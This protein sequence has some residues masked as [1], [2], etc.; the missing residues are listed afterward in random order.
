MF[1]ELLGGG[2]Q[3]AGRRVVRC[4]EVEARVF[5]HPAR[6]SSVH[7]SKGSRDSGG[8]GESDTAFS[9]QTSDDD[10]EDGGVSL[11]EYMAPTAPSKTQL[12]VPEN[13]TPQQ[14][15]RHRAANREKVRQAARRGTIFGFLAHALEP[16]D[17]SLISPQT[18]DSN[19]DGPRRRKVEA[20]QGGR[21]VEASFAKGPWGVRWKDEHG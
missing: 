19:S 3:G 8:E 6:A 4:D 5:G 12:V 18:K 7:P 13:L 1:V 11:G 21:I 2:E 14:L 9:D 15:G 17:A 20:V 10:D 16:T